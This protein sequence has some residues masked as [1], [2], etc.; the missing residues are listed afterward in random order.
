MNS[1]VH[2]APQLPPAIDG[3]GDYCWNLWR[4]WPEPDVRWKFLALHN[5][6]QTRAHWREVEVSGFE[7]NA[8]SLNR[9]L[10]TAGAETV[11]L[12]Y[13][14]YG[15]QP[16]GVPLWLPE[17]LR[18]WREGSSGKSQKQNADDERINVRSPRLITMFHEMYARSSP[19]R[20]PF[21]VARK[22]V[23]QS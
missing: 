20:S 12:H 1:V 13:V 4:H 22:P 3:V 19:L 7:A 10:E 21:W 9:A 5:V 6:P 23:I 15:F 17:T 2:I 16:K 11:V 14:S 18:R 8:Y